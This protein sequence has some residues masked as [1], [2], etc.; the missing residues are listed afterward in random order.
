[1][2]EI[3]DFAQ[4]KLFASPEKRLRSGR[5]RHAEA[6]NSFVTKSEQRAP[7]AERSRKQA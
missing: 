5:Q 1:M 4:G 2:R 3:F 6:R 7:E